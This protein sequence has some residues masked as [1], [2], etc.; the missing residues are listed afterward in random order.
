MQTDGIF[1]IFPQGQAGELLGL[2]T[3]QGQGVIELLA[4]GIA[5]LAPEVGAVVG[6]IE[7][8]TASRT[9]AL[10]WK[11]PR[12]SIKSDCRPGKREALPHSEANKIFL[13]FSTEALRIGTPDSRA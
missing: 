6:F 10:R 13:A 8:E 1:R 3:L 9:E 12:D 11:W 7:A 4:P 5:A 2:G